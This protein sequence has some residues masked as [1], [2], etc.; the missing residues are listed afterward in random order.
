MNAV[1]TSREDYA[2]LLID[3]INKAV[4]EDDWATVWDNLETLKGVSPCLYRN[5]IRILAPLAGG[6]T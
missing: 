5:V 2:V 4:L 6:L 3:E 1:I